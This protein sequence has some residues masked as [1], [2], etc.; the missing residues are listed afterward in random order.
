MTIMQGKIEQADAEVKDS[1]EVDQYQQLICSFRPL[2]ITNPSDLAKELQTLNGPG[3][4]TPSRSSRLQQFR[5]SRL[6][7]L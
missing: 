7:Q 3:S 2:L 4:T 6:A 5:Y 1:I